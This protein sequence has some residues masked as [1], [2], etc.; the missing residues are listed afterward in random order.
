MDLEYKILGKGKT[1]LVIETG[2][3][4]SF[5]DW[6]SIV[7]DL[8]ED[9]TVV[10]YHRCGY[11]KSQTPK[12]PRTTKNIAEELNCLLES[13]GIK[14]RFILM[15]HSFGGLC[16]Q[17]YAKMYPYKLK[18][19]VLLDSTS[20][21]YKQLYMLHTPVMNSLIEIDKM[22]ESNIDSSK[23]SKEELRQQNRSII[24]AY[25]NLISDEDM[26]A[27]EEFFTSA[28]LHKTI[29]EEF[30][31]WHIDSN[32]IRSIPEFPNIPL[33][34]IARDNKVAE[35]EWI[36]YNI[37][38]KEA[39]LY[40]DQWRKLQIELSR[41]SEQGRLVIAENSEHEIY[42]ERP[43]IVINSLKTLIS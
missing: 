6:Y 33:I 37:L 11:G 7:E 10:L 4:G 23:K 31:N 28:M 22:V 3:G 2:I 5:Y 42:L 1:V 18:G 14:E 41:L 40:E 38:E 29:A 26:K 25:E 15:G 24:S 12:T 43:D 30:E 21:N 35:K 32:E 9:F 20:F 13:I 8:K 39:I 19:I 34:V 17:H 16:V 27:V 36:K